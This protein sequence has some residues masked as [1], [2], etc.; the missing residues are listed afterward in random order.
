MLHVKK[1]EKDVK[2][3]A[4][5]KVDIVVKEDS[6]EVSKE[7]LKEDSNQLMFLH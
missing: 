5:E 6:K 7:D 2:K 4:L 3:E 1:V